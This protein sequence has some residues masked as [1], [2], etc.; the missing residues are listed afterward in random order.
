MIAKRLEHLRDRLAL[1]QLMIAGDNPDPRSAGIADQLK[2]MIERHEL[3]LGI[4]DIAIAW[5]SGSAVGIELGLKR[6]E[7]MS[8]CAILEEPD[9][10]G[11]GRIV[12]FDESAM[13]RHAGYGSPN[14]ALQQALL[15]GYNEWSP[16]TMDRFA[17]TPA[18]RKCIAQTELICRFSAGECDAREFHAAMARLADSD[19]QNAAS[20]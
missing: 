14:E 7:N 13:Y 18:W 11:R 10:S 3:L 17:V 8:Y 15:D 2:K 16:G 20:T 1:A 6:G 12:Y 19:Q 4:Y 9:D 5:N